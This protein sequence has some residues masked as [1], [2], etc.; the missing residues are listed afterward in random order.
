MR[1]TMPTL[2]F[3]RHL[4]DMGLF[5]SMYDR[6]NTEH[7]LNS[8]VVSIPACHAGDPGSSPGRGDFFYFLPF[9]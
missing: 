5:I 3:D 1:V 2:W 8:I 7:I 4:I 9:L 6:E